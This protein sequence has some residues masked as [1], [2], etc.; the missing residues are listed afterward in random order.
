MPNVLTLQCARTLR[1]LPTIGLEGY[2]VFSSIYLAV[3][4]LQQDYE[5]H[6]PWGNDNDVGGR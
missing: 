1:F 5:F 3:F 4:M 6:I 2:V